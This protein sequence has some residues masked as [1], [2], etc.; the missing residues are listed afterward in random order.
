[1]EINFIPAF[2]RGKKEPPKKEQET[3]PIP[4]AGRSSTNDQHTS[5][6]FG[7]INMLNYEWGNLVPQIRRLAIY[8]PDVSLVV[9]DTIKLINTGFVIKFD[10]SV[11]PDLAD[12][13]K[14]HI[15]NVAKKWGNKGGLN[16]LVNRKIAQLLISG[17]L[18]SE[19]VVKN[20]LSGVHN[21][22]LI[23]PE[24]IRFK[25]NKKR[26]E[27]VAYQI[28]SDG[29]MKG[30]DSGLIKLNDLTFIYQGLGSDSEIPYGIPP[31]LPALDVIKDQVQMKANIS[32]LSK[33]MGLLGFLQAKIKKPTMQANESEPQYRSRL[34]G[35]LK[36][37]KERIV[38][39]MSQGV[40]VS[41]EE[42]HKFDFQALSKNSAGAGEL[43]NLNEVQ[44]A[45]ALK[46]PGQFLGIPSSSTESMLTVVFT[47][48]ISQLNNIQELLKTD[49]EFGINLELRLAGFKYEFLEIKFNKSTI[50]DELKTQQAREILIRNLSKLYVDGII[51]QET[52]AEEMGYEAPDED[53]PRIPLEQVDGTEGAVKKQNREKSKDAN[54]KKNR[55]K[56]KPVPKRK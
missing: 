41:F 7:N 29:A 4:P 13:M 8:N 49:L 24:T 46:T 33:I 19:W 42:D 55:E 1:M 17:A 50:T 6:Y 30:M 15:N 43:F 22:F 14:R 2:L 38:E 52:Y 23:D 54:D 45:N 26:M 40:V 10:K 5:G 35:L 32:W 56:T 48:M 47:K 44:V 12:A 28:S 37:H 27:Y 21:N 18:A 34:N 16:G 20:D 31:Y 51:S 11:D 3:E 39:G 36:R 53:E 9:Q 25:Y